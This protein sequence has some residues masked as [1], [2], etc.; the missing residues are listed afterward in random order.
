MSAKAEY[1]EREIDALI[2]AA[3]KAEREA[4][5]RIAESIGSGPYSSTAGWALSERIA[6]AIRNRQ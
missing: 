6:A 4:C 1:S 3:V 5:A 2:A